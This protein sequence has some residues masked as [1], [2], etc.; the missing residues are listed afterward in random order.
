MSHGT[1]AE[2]LLK[3]LLGDFT[4][5]HAGGGLA[6]A[7]TLEHRTGIVE[8]ILAH[9]GQ[10][11]MARTRTA[12][13]RIATFTRQIAVEGIGAHYFGPL[14]PFGV[15]DFDGHRRAERQSMTYASEQSHLILFELHTGATTIAEPTAGQR[16]DDVVG[17]DANAGRQPLD[18]GH[19]GLSM[20]LPCC[21]PAQHSIPRFVCSVTRG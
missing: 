6:G 1:N 19:Q 13:R 11:G 5:S 3:E 18:H 21:L 16:G 12:Q 9:A 14:G 10:I 2:C 17:T 15:G 20:R 8:A 7:G 4:Q